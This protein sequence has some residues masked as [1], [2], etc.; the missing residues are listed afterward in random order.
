MARK[1]D[2]ICAHPTEGEVSHHHPFRAHVRKVAIS[3][4]WVGFITGL[5]LGWALTR[6]VYEIPY[7]VR[8]DYQ[9]WRI[10]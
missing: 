10:R 1:E 2:Y 4:A 7:A 6:A 3:A 5:V 9:L 8:Q